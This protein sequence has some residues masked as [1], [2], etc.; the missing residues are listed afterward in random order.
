MNRS[1]RGKSPH[2]GT[3]TSHLHG[4]HR[5]D[6]G[7]A[8]S[9]SDMVALA[10][11]GRSTTFCPVLSQRRSDGVQHRWLSG[12][13]AARYPRKTHRGSLQPRPH[14]EDRCVHAAAVLPDCLLDPVLWSWTLLAFGLELIRSGWNQRLHRRWILLHRLDLCAPAS[15]Q[16]E[17]LRPP[18]EPILSPRAGWRLFAA[19]NSPWLRFLVE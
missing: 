16:V 19:V 18:R 8:V 13:T 2:P 7:P 14:F 5:D 12:R 15:I 6:A 10:P 3:W 4:G 9:Y 11:W 1:I 17:P